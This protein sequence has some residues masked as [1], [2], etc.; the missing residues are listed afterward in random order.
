MF[1]LSLIISVIVSHHYHRNHQHHHHLLLFFTYQIILPLLVDIISCLFSCFLS[2]PSVRAFSSFLFSLRIV[3]SFFSFFVYLRWSW[4][5]FE[6]YLH[7]WACCYCFV[8]LQLIFIRLLSGIVAL[9]ACLPYFLVSSFLL[10]ILPLFF[11]LGA[12]FFTYFFF[13]LLSFSSSFVSH[14]LF[15]VFASHLHHP[16]FIPLFSFFVPLYI[17]FHPIP[18]SHT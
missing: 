3:V 6:P 8:F 1:F 10:F 5:H 11:F 7:L 2:F 16:S 9:F 12:F 17:I 18:V 15:F 4:L 14:L 13:L